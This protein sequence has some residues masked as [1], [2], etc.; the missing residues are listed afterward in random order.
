M[1]KLGHKSDICVNITT[2][3]VDFVNATTLQKP[4]RIYDTRST[5]PENCLIARVSKVVTA[6]FTEWLMLN[7]F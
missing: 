6:I 1:S 3:M 5:A 4:T 2:Q 7:A